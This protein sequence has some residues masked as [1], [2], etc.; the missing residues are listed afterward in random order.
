MVITLTTTGIGDKKIIVNTINKKQKTFPGLLFFVILVLNMKTY[1]K[2]LLALVLL[3]IAAFLIYWFETKTVTTENIT[4]NISETKVLKDGEY[5]ADTN[6]MTPA[7][8]ETVGI[9][10]SLT[11]NKITSLMVANK[12]NDKTSS[13]FQ[14]RF[15]SGI[16]S[17]ALGQNIDNLNVGVVS[18]ASL[19]SAA[20][21]QALAKVKTLAAN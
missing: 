2:Y 17:V 20:F 21:E 6:Y 4:N 14:N 19:T 13:K 7:G 1:I 3:C 18:G 5:I 8:K 9:K 10:I 11:G 15:I 12:A 16:Q